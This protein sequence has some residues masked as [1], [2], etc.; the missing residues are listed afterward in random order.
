MLLARVTG[1]AR[2]RSPVP[3]FVAAFARRV[4]TGLL[5]ARPGARNRYAVTARAPDGITF[6][7]VD[8][9]TAINVGLNDVHIAIREDGTARYSIEYSRWAVYALGLGG[10]IGAIL[11]ATLLAL[12][13]RDYIEQHPAARFS[14]L[15]I[16]QNV[17][18][19]WA[20]A[21]FWGFAW[22]WILIALHRQPLTRLIDRIIAEVDEST[23][24]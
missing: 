11:I 24:R 10:I 12:D 9:W 15:S 17:A 14:R 7:A 1:S 6:R 22:P 2:V 3:L 4:E 16:D 8:W 20:M 5:A 23:A 19:A 13:I 21:L 18:I